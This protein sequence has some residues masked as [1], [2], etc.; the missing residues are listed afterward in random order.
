MLSWRPC[1]NQ[2]PAKTPALP[3]FSSGGSGAGSDA[4]GLGATLRLAGVAEGLAALGLEAFLQAGRLAAARRPMATPGPGGRA[5]HPGPHLD[6]RIT[7][8]AVRGWPR[9]PPP[10]A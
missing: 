7:V 8:W 9:G 5:F 4:V 6:L 3:S 1:P 10:P 2:V